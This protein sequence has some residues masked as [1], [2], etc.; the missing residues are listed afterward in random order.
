LLAGLLA[1]VFLFQAASLEGLFQKVLSSFHFSEKW[2]SRLAYL[3]NQFLL[4]TKAFA[5]PSRAVKYVALTAVVWLL[6]GSGSVFLAHG[7]NLSMSLVQALLL[8]AA[9]GISSALPSTPGY[10]GIYQFVAVT[11]MPAFGISPS[12][13]L[14]YI[15]AGQAVNICTILL[16][17]LAGLWRFGI[18]TGGLLENIR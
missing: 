18:K 9:L 10:V 2:R 14:T 4:G 7:F 11:L 5:N 8:L 1:L 6:D 3:L 15:L 17:G 16:W 13:A 12:Q